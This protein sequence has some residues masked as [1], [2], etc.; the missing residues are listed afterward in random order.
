MPKESCSVCQ[1]TGWV[2]AQVKGRS[3]AKRCQCFVQ[4]QNQI[5]FDQ[6]NIPQR[7]KDCTFEN[8]KPN[9]RTQNHAVKI[10]RKLID[11][12]PLQETG[13]VFQGPCGVGKTH[14]AVAIISE[15]IW[16]KNAVCYFYDFRQL[17]RSLQSSYSAD[18]PISESEVL[19]PVFEKKVLVLDELGA[20]RT[21][22]WVEETIFYIINNR[23]N[24]KQLTIFTTNYL[25][26]DKDEPEEERQIPWSNRPIHEP[27]RAE[28]LEKR[29]GVRLHSRIYE[30]CKI[31]N[32]EGEDFRKT[33]LQANFR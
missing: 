15:L 31:V 29:I 30:M 1:D 11:N 3:V 20:K 24:N 28:S 32:V 4:R 25:D 5:L 8:F 16:K 19:A 10:A 17:I 23:Y 21:T 18:S 12:F 13:L 33:A 27:K 14:L 6:A 26:F 9:N 22:P 7:Y 2:L